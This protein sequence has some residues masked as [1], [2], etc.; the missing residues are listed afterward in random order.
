MEALSG[1][2]TLDQFGKCSQ[3]EIPGKWNEVDE[4]FYNQYLFYFAFENN[5]CE[6]Y[7]T[8]KFF[9]ILRLRSTI[10]IVRGAAKE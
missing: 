7:V 5:L 2:L 1:R 8:E 6:D 10:P 9:K 4:D 3:R